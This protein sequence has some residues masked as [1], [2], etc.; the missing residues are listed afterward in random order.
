MLSLDTRMRPNDEQVIGKVLDGEAIVINLATGSYYAIPD[1]GAVIW[2][3][4]EERCSLQEIA[5]RV[6][7]NYEVSVE[8]AG[9]D[10]LELAERLMQEGVVAIATDIPASPAAQPTAP[11]R[12]TPYA[13]PQLVAFSDMRNLLALDP[14]MPSI[15]AL[16]GAGKNDRG[17]SNEP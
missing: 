17:S 9:A 14:P 3:G 15:D 12:R 4:I 10:A 16:G 2:Q 11:A 13:A 8:Q 5:V 7:A 1:V 6:S